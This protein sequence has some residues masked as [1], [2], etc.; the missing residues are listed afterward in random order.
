MA[1]YTMRET[2]GTVFLTISGELILNTHSQLK[3]EIK[4]HLSG[5]KRVIVDLSGVPFIDSSGL[6]MLISW[7]KSVNEADG[8]IV[9]ASLNPYVRK[10]IK[11]SK[12]DK[13]FLLADTPTEAQ[14]LL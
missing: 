12:L 2:D 11:I 3:D 9:F 7:F 10:I 13:I 14:E 5:K 4:A 1:E 6:G 8:R